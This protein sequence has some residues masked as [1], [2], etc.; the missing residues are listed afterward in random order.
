MYYDSHFDHDCS[1]LWHLTD[2]FLH[3]MFLVH[4]NSLF[5]FYRVEMIR[6]MGSDRKKLCI[7]FDKKNTVFFSLFLSRFKYFVLYKQLRP[8][9]KTILCN[10]PVEIAIIKLIL[11]FN[12]M[13]K[14]TK[15]GR[16]GVNYV[17]VSVRSC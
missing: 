17:Y 1:S 10:L 2:F 12:V 13:I 4:F 14:C 9:T 5:F 3:P 16:V 8:K 7:K 6:H 15:Y 11:E